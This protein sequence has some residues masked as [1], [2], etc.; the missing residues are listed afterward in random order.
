MDKLK[1]ERV[2]MLLNDTQHGLPPVISGLVAA[3]NDGDLSRIWAKLDA[4]QS[5]RNDMSE[6]LEILTKECHDADPEL[7]RQTYAPWK[8]AAAV[9][10]GSVRSEAKSVTSRNNGA[11]GGRPKLYCGCEGRKTIKH[12]GEFIVCGPNHLM[13]CK[14]C[15]FEIK[16]YAWS[17]NG[18]VI[19]KQTAGN[20]EY[21]SDV[22]YKLTVSKPGTVS[23][24]SCAHCN[25]TWRV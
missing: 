20:C 21:C 14:R 3:I 13:V 5:R 8:S 10:M 7:W 9:A 1:I 17:E 11:K 15:N 12:E 23:V 4:F 18:M 2:K 16:G 19:E 22:N 6:A 24:Y 25:R